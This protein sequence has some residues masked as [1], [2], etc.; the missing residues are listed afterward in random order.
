MSNRLKT[1][2]SPYLQMHSENPV[3]WYPWGAEAFQR[4][5]EE[6]KPIFLSIGYSACHWCHVIARESFEDN[7]IA[8]LLREDFI[9]VKVDK[10]ERPDV[11]AV[12]LL[13]SQVFT[14]SAG[15]PTTVLATPE[16]KPFFA[17]TYLPREQL[18]AVLLAAAHQW[19]SNREKVLAAADQAAELTETG[20]IGLL[21]LVEILCA[22]KVQRGQAGETVLEGT[23][24]Q[25]LADV[26]AQLY[27]CLTECRFVGPLGLAAYAELSSMAAS[28]MLGEWFD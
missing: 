10:E 8:E 20:E 25:I 14:G 7:E 2:A 23:E 18:A 12:Y 13:A 3:D 11:D 28:L 9:S 26:V 21:R 6:E 5:R 4:A 17:A 16:G 15:W 24:V 27:A 22:A 19:R 1:E